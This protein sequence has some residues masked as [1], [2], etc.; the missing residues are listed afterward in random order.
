MAKGSTVF[1]YANYRD[2]LKVRLST[3]G[4][5][6]GMRTK[7]A[8]MTGTQPA[9]ISRVLS[10]EL[11]FAPEHGPVIHEL[12]NHTSDE[13]HYFMLLLS[14]AR[15]GNIK[16]QS[17]YQEQ[18]D[19]IL[20]KR[21]QFLTRIKD[22]EAVQVEDQA[23]YYSQWYYL[24]IHVLVGI[25]QYQTRDAL[26]GRLGLSSVT[27][28]KALEDL[29]RMG[30]V[31]M[32]SGKFSVGKKRIYLAKQSP[33]ISNLHMHFRGRVIHRLSE[34]QPDDLHFSAAIS[35]SKKTFQEYRKRLLDLMS[36]MDERIVDSKDEE[37]Y[38]ISFDLFRY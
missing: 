10:G 21:K 37:I 34:P 27:V 30:L 12:L 3:T 28:G 11:D 18:I 35:V 8:A 17:Y 26:A 20:E 7:L 38:A 23:I 5:S 6:R 16:L 9:F 31:E 2:Y 32:K 22:S 4:E 1:E 33:W 36:E 19:G 14:K 13:A 15:A 29:L 24:A 25:P